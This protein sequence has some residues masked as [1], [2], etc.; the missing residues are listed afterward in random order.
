MEENQQPVAPTTQS[1]PLQ[2]PAPP[3]PQPVSPSRHIPKLALILVVL[4]ILVSLSFGGFYLYKNLSVPISPTIPIPTI[5]SRSPT[6]T[7]PPAGG[8][9]TNWKTYTNKDYNFSIIHPPNTSVKENYLDSV[10]N[11]STLTSDQLPE[12]YSIGV[13]IS[14][15]SKHLSSQEVVDEAIYA[16]THNNHFEYSK[17]FEDKLESTVEPYDVGEING[18][19]YRYP[20]RIHLID[21]RSDY[22][23]EFVMYSSTD[24]EEEKAIIYQIL[25]TFKFTE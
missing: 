1:A 20:P 18:L 15:N 12:S 3:S 24:T 9:T 19:L 5:I 16:Y 7:L 8:P 22:I 2:T 6:P 11:I 17:S 25:S 21:A 23:Y 4:F 14:T 10:I 13:N